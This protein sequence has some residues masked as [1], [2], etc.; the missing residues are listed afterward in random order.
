MASHSRKLGTHGGANDSG[1]TK[2]I[3]K[4]NLL[5]AMV[6]QMPDG[7]GLTHANPQAKLF[8]HQR[9]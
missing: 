4:K 9:P 2:K 5:R 1:L 7:S 8:N 6:G 3:W